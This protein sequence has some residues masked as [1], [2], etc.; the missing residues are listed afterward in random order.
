MR[1]S[2]A[3]RHRTLPDDRVAG[4]TARRD[5]NGNVVPGEFNQSNQP[6]GSGQDQPMNG[7]A[8]PSMARAMAQNQPWTGDATG[9]RR[10]TIPSNVG[11][12]EPAPGL[13]AFSRA[14]NMQA[15]APGQAGYGDAVI[16]R[17]QASLAAARPAFS[18]GE[19]PNGQPPNGLPVVT[20]PP[21]PTP[22]PTPR[23]DPLQSLSQRDLNDPNNRGAINSQIERQYATPTAGASIAQAGTVRQ[24]PTSTPL[25]P[26]AIVDETGNRT[27]EFQPGGKGSSEPARTRPQLPPDAVAAILKAYPTVGQAGHADNAAFV[28]ALTK[29]HDPNNPMTADSALNLAHGIF[30]DNPKSSYYS[31]QSVTPTKGF[32]G[33]AA[34]GQ[35]VPQAANDLTLGGPKH[36]NDISMSTTPR[37]QQPTG[38]SPAITPNAA[39]PA[40]QPFSTGGI[41]FNNPPA[42]SPQVNVGGI[43]VGGAGTGPAQ[44]K[45]SVAQQPAPAYRPPPFDP[46]VTGAP[47]V[48]QNQQQKPAWQPEQKPFEVP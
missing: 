44:P 29:A 48:A 30:R 11:V 17:Q 15:P 39:P 40:Q 22:S 36:Q 34:G 26:R 31:P 35:P 8:S 2:M 13:N 10:T 24:V 6:L 32:Y 14:Q 28:Q 18:F 25:S 5:P 23:V 38:T 45:T 43:A 16:S 41:A 27:A 3:S 21:S 12:E 46:A 19:P 42:T 20:P 9:T 33:E 37:T 47:P 4:G 1:P 7:N